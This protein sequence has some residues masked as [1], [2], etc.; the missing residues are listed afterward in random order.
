[1]RKLFT[2]TAISFVVVCFSAC[3]PKINTKL[4]A[5]RKA[6]PEDADVFVLQVDQQAPASAVNIGAIR[7]GDTGFS[8][9]CSWETVIENAKVEARKA[10][11]L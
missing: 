7:V 10:G 1:M 6:L 5:A 8:T 4:E 11:G 9:K 2:L 3:S